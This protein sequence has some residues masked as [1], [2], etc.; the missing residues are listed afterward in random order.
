MTI[1]TSIGTMPIATILGAT[2]PDIGQRKAARQK[3][4]AFPSHE[5]LLILHAPGANRRGDALRS[6]A[7]E[8]L[9]LRPEQPEEPL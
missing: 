2:D 7:P 6:A 1:T 3:T 5:R 9:R 4:D 8:P